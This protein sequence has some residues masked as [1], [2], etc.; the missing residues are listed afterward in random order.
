MVTGG[1]PCQDLSVAGK[2]AGLGGARSG[3]FM[4]QIRIIR[5]MRARDEAG[6][7]A[8]RDVRPRFCVWE[9]VPGSLS[10]NGGEDFRIV[11]EEFCR[12]KDPAATVPRPDRGGGGTLLGQSWETVTALPGASWTVNSGESPNVAVE[13]HLWQILQD[14]APRK[15]YLSVR[16][17]QGILRR[18]ERRGKELPKV[19]M[20]AL[21]EMVRDRQ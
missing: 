1:S 6:G 3:L 13:S 18:A 2:R 16:A 17:A 15:Y 8:D 9:N 19:L 5:E 14:N 10:S 7:R 4:E 12:I 20:E 11:L 21:T